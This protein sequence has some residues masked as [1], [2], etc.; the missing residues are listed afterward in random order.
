[1]KDYLWTQ[2]FVSQPYGW[3]ISNRLKTFRWLWWI[4][5]LNWLNDHSDRL[6]VSI[7]FFWGIVLIVILN[8]N[9]FLRL[10]QG[11]K[12]LRNED[13]HHQLCLIVSN[14]ISFCQPA[15]IKVITIL[16]I[17]CNKVKSEVMRLHFHDNVRCK[18]TTAKI[19]AGLQFSG[20]FYPV[21]LAS[22][23]TRLIEMLSF[24]CNTNKRIHRSPK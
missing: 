21:P 1:M 2:T 24:F 12:K 19:M 9:N 5:D 14:N 16:L 23:C 22:P 15:A 18:K 10:Y 4:D 6:A 7:H 11:C 13:I 20:T 3:K 17:F 8:C